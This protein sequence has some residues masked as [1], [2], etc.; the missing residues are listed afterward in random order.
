LLGKRRSR[1]PRP[2]MPASTPCALRTD[3]P[4]RPRADSSASHAWM[5]P[6]ST[7]RSGRGY[8]RGPTCVRSTSSYLA[9]VVGL[10]LIL[11]A[12]Q[13]GASSPTVIFARSGSSTSPCERRSLP[14]PATPAPQPYARSDAHVR[15][16][17]RRGSAPAND[18]PAVSQCWPWPPPEPS[19]HRT[20]AAPDRQA[21]TM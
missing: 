15:V 14:S 4:D 5:S 20:H 17:T 19:R 11:P 8:H 18:R 2:R 3:A 12:S 1:T 10:R 7:R 9:R 16:Q 21:G 13:I 6:C